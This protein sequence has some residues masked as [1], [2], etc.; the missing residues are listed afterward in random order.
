[1]MRI[2]I[3]VFIVLII[4]AVFCRS[5]YS[6]SDDKQKDIHQLETI[7]VTAQ[8]KEENPQKVPVSVDVFSD[9]RIEDAK[10]EDVLDLTRFSPNVHMKQNYTEHVIVIRGIPS[11]RA[12][13]HSPAGLYVDDVSYPL[14][15]MQNTMLFDIERAEVLKG[16][17]GTLYG[18]NTESGVI[19]IITRQP[20]NQ[21]RSKVFGEYGSDDTFRSGAN[22]SGPLVSDTLFVGAAFQ[23]KISDGYA[24]NLS[25]GNDQV[26]DSEQVN[27]RTALRWTPGDAWDIS[28]TADVMNA[29]NHI[30]GYRL[31][32]GPHASNPFE[33]RK[34]E[35][36]YYKEDGN[37]QG[38]RIKYE[39]SMFHLL[40][41]SGALY[42]TLDKLADTDLWD[43]PGD[44]KVNT[45]KIRERQYSQEFRM[46]S[47]Q[48]GAFEWLAG[49]YG[50]ME[51][52]EFNY[53]YDI[54]SKGITGKHPIANMD[55]DGYAFFGQGTYTLFED[56]HL[57]AGL[58]FDHQDLE[59]DLRDD[60]KGR[61][62]SQDLTY[63][64][65]LPKFSIAYDLSKDFMVYTSAS[66]G[67]LVGGYNWLMNPTSETFD[68]DSEYTWNYELG[69]KTTCLKGK[70]IANL[71]VFYTDIEDKQV[72]EFDADTSSNTVTNAANA[73]SQGVEF[74]VRTMPV[75]GLEIVAGF[76]YTQA[77]FDEFKATEWNDTHTALIENDYEDKYLPYAPE[78]TYN[79]GIQYRSANGLLCRADLLGTDRY[80]GDIGN[81]SE[82]DAYQTVNLRLGYEKESFDFYL[83]AENLFDEEYLTYVAPFDKNSHVGFDG[84]PRTLGAT[85]TYRF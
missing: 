5:A 78:Y 62:C 7:T 55:T 32:S 13:T 50:F 83:W 60:I 48:K 79:L 66:K 82:Q 10:I 43:D 17:Q 42:Q 71:S 33:V 56:L 58:R 41:V 74:Q 18:R 47:A 20:D 19:N 53:K 70:L 26:A 1:M 36:E 67:Y 68:Y 45:F 52:T 46:S 27:A 6:G 28:L 9:I 12:S 16:P 8:K 44:R 81:L 2:H 54:V 75:Q 37:S 85:L 15:Y 21:F 63:D 61:H 73:H 69:I 14:H 24:E 64:E 76:G 22:I 65:Y 29:D 49:V 34:D 51:E 59:G 77:K 84:P 23:Y 40:S 39:G 25:D 11:F 80:Y 57:T 38:L 4:S 72:T 30:G 3:K 35:D 31:I